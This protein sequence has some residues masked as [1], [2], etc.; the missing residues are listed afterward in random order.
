MSDPL[1]LR[2]EDRADFETVLHLALNT[3]DI[4]RAVRADP[5]GRA[6]ARLRVRVLADADEIAGA[7]Q[8]EYRRYLTLDAS[9]GEEPPRYPMDGSVLPALAVLTPLVAGSSAAVLL[10]LGYV[11]RLSDSQGS[12]PGPLVTAGW[13]LALV[14]AASALTALGAMLAVAIRGRRGSAHP[15]RLEQARLEWQQALLARGMLPC[16]RRYI[17]EDPSLRPAPTTSA[18]DSNG[19]PPAPT[20]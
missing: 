11:L 15:A 18:A 20:D 13:I 7:A 10:V 1:C 3:Q 6:A 5:T 9:A 19:A 16:L 2:P 17:A 14:A 8:G 12:L 4:R